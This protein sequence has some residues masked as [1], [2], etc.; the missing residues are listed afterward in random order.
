MRFIDEDLLEFSQRLLTLWDK[1]MESGEVELNMFAF[2][3]W[4][5]DQ[6][7]KEIEAGL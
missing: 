6:Y 1:Y 5:Q 7:D 2:M 4:L 3:M